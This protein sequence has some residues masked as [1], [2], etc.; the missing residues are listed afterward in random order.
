MVSRQFS[1]CQQGFTLLS[2]VRLDAWSVSPVQ[3]YQSCYTGTMHRVGEPLYVLHSL[4]DRLYS[5]EIRYTVVS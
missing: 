4:L 5:S 1:T 2:K 3:L